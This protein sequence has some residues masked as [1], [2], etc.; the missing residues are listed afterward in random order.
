M[1]QLNRV[2]FNKRSKKQ[3]IERYI[4]FSVISLLLIFI[5]AQFVVLNLAGMRGPKITRLRNEQERLKLDNELKRAQ[6]NEL[7][8]SEDIKN[9]ATNSLR[10]V[11]KSV[12]TVNIT[13][14]NVN[15]LDK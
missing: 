3:Q 11:P 8:K 13:G 10:L 4:L 2:Y 14:N 1:K 9:F 7:T 6:I 15:A 5:L 12:E